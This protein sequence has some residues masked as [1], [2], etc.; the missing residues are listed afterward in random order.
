MK[1]VG[2]YGPDPVTGTVGGVQCS[3]DLLTSTDPWP[4][5]GG[6]SSHS[7][8]TPAHQDGGGGESPDRGER[9]SRSPGQLAG[10]DECYRR[11]GV[12]KVLE[13][14]QPPR[15]R[16]HSWGR[17]G[18]VWSVMNT[19]RRGRLT[20]SQGALCW[21]GWS[22]LQEM[23]QRVRENHRPHQELPTRVT[24]T[25]GAPATRQP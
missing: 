5:W 12:G 2:T 20:G 15:G 4:A 10:E 6:R 18:V 19:L 8:E 16:E 9:K 24:G 23:R 22:G 25:L 13:E 1:V 7:N 11:E 21:A 14:S 17:L 3:T